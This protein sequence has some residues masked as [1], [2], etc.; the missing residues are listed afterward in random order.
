[1]AG[2]T[3]PLNSPDDDAW[4]R[5]TTAAIAA[6]CGAE[7]AYQHRFD[8]VYRAVQDRIGTTSSPRLRAGCHAAGGPIGDRG[9][10]LCWTRG[11]E[12]AAS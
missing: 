2:W 11:S 12:K 3:K 9:L 6:G 7:I 4:A 5:R 10:P 1:M 8:F